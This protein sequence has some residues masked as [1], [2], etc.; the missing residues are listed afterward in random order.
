[1]NQHT[2]TAGTSDAS[3]RDNRTLRR[4]T[5][6]TAIASYN[7]QSIS[8]EVVLRDISNTGVKLK[9]NADEPLP[10]HFTL[11]IE[12]DGLLVDCE[13]VWRHGMEIGARFISEIKEYEPTKKQ[14]VQ[15]STRHKNSLI[16]KPLY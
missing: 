1:M 4:R 3:Q 8:F 15:S 11:N 12:L 2:N 7:N 9:L 14:L 6:K 16:R 13:V 5:L 10:D